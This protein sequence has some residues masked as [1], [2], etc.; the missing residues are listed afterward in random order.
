MAKPRIVALH[1][2]KQ[3]V[4]A[5]EARTRDTPTRLDIYP[6]NT[7]RG[8]SE[9]R[10]RNGI[11]IKGKSREE[12]GFGR[13]DYTDP[14]AGDGWRLNSKGEKVRTVFREAFDEDI[15]LSLSTHLTY[16][17]QCIKQATLY[18]KLLDIDL[19]N[20]EEIDIEEWLKRE[21]LQ[22]GPESLKKQLALDRVEE[23]VEEAKLFEAP[24]N[25]GKEMKAIIYVT[26]AI[27]QAVKWQEAYR[28]TST[29]VKERIKMLLA[30]RHEVLYGNIYHSAWLGTYSGPPPKPKSS[31][32]GLSKSVASVE[33]SGMPV[34][35]PV[36]I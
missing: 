9:T 18:A 21:V 22:P 31:C 16:R 7:G 11:P 3:S 6:N 17:I 29:A 5:N 15:L 25:G 36:I 13:K 30:K 14:E 32:P 4:R 2:E 20:C 33:D 28:D 26:I 24:T 23:L 19:V 35:P 8:R 1:P 10:Q 12:R 34:T 27:I